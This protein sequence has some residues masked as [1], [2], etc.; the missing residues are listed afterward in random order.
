MKKSADDALSIGILLFFIVLAMCW[1]MFK[2]IG[3]MKNVTR[4]SCNE[5]LKIY[6]K[7]RN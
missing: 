2:T 3:E 4:R 6:E 5:C 1:H 7:I